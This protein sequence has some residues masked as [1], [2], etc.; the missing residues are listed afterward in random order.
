MPLGYRVMLMVGPGAGTTSPV[1]RIRA[2]YVPFGNPAGLLNSTWLSCCEVNPEELV[3]KKSCCGPPPLSE[4][5]QF[6]IVKRPSPAHGT[7]LLSVKWNTQGLAERYRTEFAPFESCRCPNCTAA[8][9][10]CQYAFA[11]VRFLAPAKAPPLSAN[12]T[13][14]I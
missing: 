1:A 9:H 13:S 7:P 6:G 5:D 12:P 10:S 11:N 8:C 3:P 14:R 2:G 4:P